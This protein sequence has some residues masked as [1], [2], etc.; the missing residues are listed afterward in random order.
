M[1]MRRAAMLAGLILLAL[2]AGVGC[3]STPRASERTPAPERPART[4]G[5]VEI[6]RSRQGRALEAISVGSGPLRVYIIGAIHGDEGEGRAIVDPLVGA[7]S[8]D[9]AY[10]KAT[11]RVLRDANPD[12]TAARTRGNA[13]GLDL[14]RNWPARSFR[15]GAQRGASALSEPE[16]AAVHRDLM[17]FGPQIVV[18]FHS[19][20]SGPFVNFDGPA[21]GLA[22][23]FAG[24]AR[25]SDARW[26]V[27]PDMGYR[28][29]G[30][31]G[32]YF[33]VDRGVPILTIEFRRGQDA[34]S[35]LAAARSGIGAV[36]VEGAGGRPLSSAVGPVLVSG[37][38]SGRAAR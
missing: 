29:P 31:L 12:G 9:G 38:R 2:G 36:V 23:A 25:V 35:C 15:A 16:T 32:S 7:L 30:S 5:W 11:L 10:S 13:Q 4:V 21:R 33:G 28:T 24:A 17:E 34:A 19:S 27:V 18:V 37:W 8:E 6:G 20:R 1:V 3:H 22:E 14:N 26:R